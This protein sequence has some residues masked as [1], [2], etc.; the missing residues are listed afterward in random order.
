MQDVH[1]NVTT[2][3]RQEAF[4]HVVEF[5]WKQHRPAR[6]LYG[7][8]A[9]INAKGSMCAVGCLLPIAVAEA[10]EAVELSNGSTSISALSEADIDIVP[11]YMKDD[12]DFYSDLQ[13]A[14]DCIHLNDGTFAEQFIPNMTR[15][16]R[17]YKLDETT[18]NRVIKTKP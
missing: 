4:D 12:I 13:T 9:Y 1:D 6:K 14:H 16:A 7:S 5:L 11:Q 18:L 15:V 3:T 17:K 10:F 8:C 2:Y